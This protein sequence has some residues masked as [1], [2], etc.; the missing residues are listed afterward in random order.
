VRRASLERYCFESKPIARVIP[1]VARD[2]C[3]GLI[4]PSLRSG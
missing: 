1:S 2:L 3:W 4:D